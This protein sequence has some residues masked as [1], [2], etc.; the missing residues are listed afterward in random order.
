MI[1]P[2]TTYVCTSYTYHEFII[3]GFIPLY[4]NG[5]I[6]KVNTLLIIFFSFLF[7]FTPLSNVFWLLMDETL[8][9]S[10]FCFYLLRNWRCLYLSFLHPFNKSLSSNQSHTFFPSLWWKGDLTCSFTLVPIEW[11]PQNL[12]MTFTRPCFCGIAIPKPLI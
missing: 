2:A 1:E 8:F 12:I 4:D 7:F 6:T 5:E 11:L 3:Q 10:A 9:L